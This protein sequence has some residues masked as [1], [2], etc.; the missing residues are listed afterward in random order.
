MPNWNN[1][2]LLKNHFSLNSLFLEAFVS[3]INWKILSWTFVS[4]NT[5]LSKHQLLLQFQFI[6]QKDKNII[7]IISFNVQSPNN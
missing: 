1:N 2:F 4:K 3:Y 7:I 5:A 6:D